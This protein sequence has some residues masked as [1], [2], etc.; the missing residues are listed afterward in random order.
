[1]NANW[2]ET[3][4]VGAHSDIG[5]GYNLGDGE[6]RRFNIFNLSLKWMRND[7]AGYSAPF[8]EIP[9][10][11]SDTRLNGYHVNESNWRNDKII[12]K[13]KKKTQIRTAYDSSGNKLKEGWSV[14]K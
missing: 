9:A 5:G 7:G 1:M 13:V 3:F 12:E 6:S 4:M 10:Q 11:F 2:H 8:G 14:V